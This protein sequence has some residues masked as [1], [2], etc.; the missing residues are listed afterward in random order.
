[1][2]AVKKDLSPGAVAPVF[3]LLALLFAAA[4]LSRFDG[5][6]PHVP[7]PVHGAALVASFPLLMIGAGLERRIDYGHALKDMPLWMQI[8][9]RPVRWFFSL[10]LTYLGLVA[11]QVLDLDLGTIDPN[12]PANWPPAQRLGWFVMFSF[13]MSFA[14]LLAATGALVPA[15]RVITGPFV[16]LPPLLG[17]PLLAALGLGLGSLALAGLARAEDVRLVM[18]SIEALKQ[19]PAIALAVAVGVVAVPLALERIWQ[20]E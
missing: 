13:G 19:Q 8:D 20:R 7:P 14:S 3:A 6:A 17:V 1:M 2:P 10:A 15:L 16:R 12:P 11:L 4:V 5:F 9:S 18:A